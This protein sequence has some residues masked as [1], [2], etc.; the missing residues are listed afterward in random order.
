MGNKF[1]VSTLNKFLYLGIVIVAIVT[2]IGFSPK[3]GFDFGIYCGKLIYIFVIPFALSWITS[4]LL[5]N[6]W[7]VGNNIFTIILVLLFTE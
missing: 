2:F 7:D 6:K 4:L 3:T 1:K 5:K